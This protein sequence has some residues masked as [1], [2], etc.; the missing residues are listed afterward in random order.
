MKVDTDKFVED[1]LKAITDKVNNLSTL[2]IIVAGKTG[3]LKVLQ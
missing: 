1:T 2:N 3:V